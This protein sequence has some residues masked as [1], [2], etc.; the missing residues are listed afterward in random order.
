MVVL[1]NGSAGADPTSN[2]AASNIL[3]DYL[4]KGRFPEN[5]D[6]LPEDA[7]A[8]DLDLVP[9]QADRG[10]RR[11]RARVHGRAREHRDRRLLQHRARRPATSRGRHRQRGAHALQQ[12][13]HRQVA[14]RLR[15]ARRSPRPSSSCSRTRNPPIAG[16]A[17]FQNVPVGIDP[18]TWPLDID[19][20]ATERAAKKNPIYPGGTVKIFGNF[21]WGGEAEPR[22]ALHGAEEPGAAGDDLADNIDDAK[23]AQRPLIEQGMRGKAI[24]AGDSVGR[25]RAPEHDEFLFGKGDKMVARMIVYD[26]KARRTSAI[27]ADKILTLRAQ[28]APL[29]YSSS[30]GSPSAASSSCCSWS[31]SS[32]AAGKRRGQ[33]PRPVM[34]SDAGRP[35]AA[36]GRRRYAPAAAGGIDDARPPPPAPRARPPPMARW[37]ARSSRGA[38]GRLHGRRPAARSRPAATAR[39]A[40]SCSTE[41][42]V[43][44]QHASLKVEGGQFFVRDENSN[45]G[46]FLNGQRLAAGRVDPRR[47]RG[48]ATIWPRRV[49]GPA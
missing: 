3:K 38:A 43:S 9:E 20:E 37:R 30:A 46:T 25:V 12:D 36:P 22:R 23:K 10:V 33:A 6:V 11:Q 19:R 17:T 40:R 39:F 4:T 48:C 27:T 42:R 29:R 44:G 8:G 18:T 32:G 47:A 24:T 31:R 28:E 41:P 7:G 49:L 14:R 2:A 21:C 5:N 45:N 34:P 13:A 16:D 26:N 1:S 35:A 15:R